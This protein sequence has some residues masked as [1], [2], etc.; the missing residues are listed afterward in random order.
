MASGE[1]APGRG[2]WVRENEV[3]AALSA[4]E[5]ELALALRAER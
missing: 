3:R 5:K 1:G 4:I 2:W